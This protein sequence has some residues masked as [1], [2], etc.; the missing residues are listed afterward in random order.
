MGAPT[1][2]EINDMVT[3]KMMRDVMQQSHSVSVVSRQMVKGSFC[4]IVE[5]GHKNDFPVDVLLERSGVEYRIASTID[6]VISVLHEEP[7]KVICA[8]VDFSG[9]DGEEV[10]Q[11]IER[12][13]P[14][15]P[16]VCHTG[17][18]G[19]GQ[20]ISEKYPRVN[21]VLKGDSMYDL[22][23]ALGIDVVRN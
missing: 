22:L 12:H 17:S 8:I 10:I 13:A 18:W 6:D 14:R 4:L 2:M 9:H 19:D 11:Q 16:T 20:R 3:D 15:V 23:S 7:E 21:V 5:N 1:G